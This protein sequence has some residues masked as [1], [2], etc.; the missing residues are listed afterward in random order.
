MLYDAVLVA[1]ILLYLS[2]AFH[3]LLLV[4]RINAEE[5]NAVAV[6]MSVNGLVYGPH[7]LKLL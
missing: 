5:M 2:A 6:G 1:R 7:W 4:S 3:P